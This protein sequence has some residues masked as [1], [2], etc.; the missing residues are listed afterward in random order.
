MEECQTINENII[1]C[2]CAV[3]GICQ[4]LQICVSLFKFFEKWVFLAALGLHC[5]RVFS[6]VVVNRGYS[7]D[8]VHGLVIV[9]ASL[10]AGHRLQ[11]AWAPVA[12]ACGLSCCSSPAL[13]HRLNGC[14]TRA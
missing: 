10:V 7:L 12:L 4:L 14:S 1:F 13:E 3:G 5:C 2:I 8:T 9:V 6:L 11:G